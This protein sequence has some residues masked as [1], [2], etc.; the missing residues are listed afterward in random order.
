MAKTLEELTILFFLLFNWLWR[1][2]NI[3]LTN[4]Q[5]SPAVKRREL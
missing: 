4:G 2:P 5:A 1:S 3:Y